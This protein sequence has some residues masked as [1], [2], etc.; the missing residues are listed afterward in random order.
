MKKKNVLFLAS[1]YPTRVN[2][3]SGNFNEKFARAVALLNNVYVLHVIADPNTKQKEEIV[4]DEEEQL[5]SVIIYFRKKERESLF[6]KAL[7]AYR[8]FHF[9]KKGFKLISTQWGRP[10]IVHNNVLFPVGLFA[11]YL[12]KKYKIPFISTEHWTGY[13]AERRVKL[14]SLRL[15]LTKLITKKADRICPVTESLKV[16]MLEVGLKGHY[17]IVPNVVDHKLFYPNNE[18]NKNEQITFLHISTCKDEHKNI[19]GMLRSFFQLHEYSNQFELKI[20]T[21]GNPED[22]IDLAKKSGI[23][24]W[25]FLTIEGKKTPEEIAEEYR[26]ADVF[27]LFSNFETFS[28]VLAEAWSC[29]LPVV[30]SKCGGLTEISNPEIGIQVPPRNEVE[31]FEALK[32]VLDGDVKFKR[33]AILEQAKGFHNDQIAEKFSSLYK[34]ILEKKSLTAEK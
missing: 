34:E 12:K 19:T 20:I 26:L 9:Y 29:G 14:S 1:W 11:L 30:Y 10:E 31:L 6:D 15:N 2:K 3:T 27:V 25:E 23:P 8:Y 21:E 13:L 7:K 5:T 18:K 17:T 4:I 33:E 32:R 16:N 22:V 28:I 24:S